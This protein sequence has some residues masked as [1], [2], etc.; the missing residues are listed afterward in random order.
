MSRAILTAKSLD[1]QI[2]PANVY[3]FD[4]KSEAALRSL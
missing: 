3:L 4:R 1:V 2:D